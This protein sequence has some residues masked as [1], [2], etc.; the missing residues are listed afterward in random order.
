MANIPSPHWQGDHREC[1]DWCMKFGQDLRSPGEFKVMA[2]TIAAPSKA[3]IEEAKWLLGGFGP[4]HE[5]MAG[6]PGVENCPHQ[7]MSSGYPYQITP[8]GPSYRH[9]EFVAQP[10]MLGSP[11]C[12]CGN[13]R[14][15]APGAA[16]HTPC[17]KE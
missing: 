8:H 2:M 12:L 15:D 1:K 13:S 16:L 17:W 10:P 5:R 6:L 7:L 9:H 3:D 11:Y 4:T 14:T